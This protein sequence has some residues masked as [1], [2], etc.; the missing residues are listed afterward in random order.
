MMKVD[1]V[2]NYDADM[3]PINNVETGDHSMMGRSVRALWQV[4]RAKHWK[5]A[6]SLVSTLSALLIISYP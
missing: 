5:E 4:W 3:I 6:D 1:D 2:E